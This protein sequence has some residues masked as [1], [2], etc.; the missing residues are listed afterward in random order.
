MSQVFILRDVNHDHMA[1]LSQNH[2]CARDAITH[3]IH[4]GV[5]LR[6]ADL[7]HFVKQ[8]PLPHRH[9]HGVDFTGVDMSECHAAGVDFSH[10]N[11][12][13]AVMRSAHLRSCIFKNCLFAGTILDAANMH[14]CYLS[15]S[16]LVQHVPEGGSVRHTMRPHQDEFIPWDRVMARAVDLDSAC[17][18]HCLITQVDFTAATFENASLKSCMVEKCQFTSA[19]MTNACFDH[20]HVYRSDLGTNSLNS[21]S[22]TGA[23]FRS[24]EYVSVP[25]AKT[26]FESGFQF[27]R[28]VMRYVKSEINHYRLLTPEVKTD[29]T[30]QI[31][32]RLMVIATVPLLVILAWKF[33]ETNALVS[34]VSAVGAV[35][36]IALRRYFTMMLQGIMGFTWRKVND[37]EGLWKSGVRGKPLLTSLFKGMAHLHSYKKTQPPSTPS[38][39]ES[40]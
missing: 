18:D 15:G 14:G 34:L 30:R 16:M 27:P 20:S 35:S 25:L 39:G 3:L 12:T 7:V 26:I 21:A 28:M 29:Y 36:T 32:L 19:L 37:A 31:L 13:H 38:Q 6:S 33:V 2:P 9:L 4:T 24:N 17:L 1:T 40:L 23:V 22:T 8:W 10:S 11:F 5:D